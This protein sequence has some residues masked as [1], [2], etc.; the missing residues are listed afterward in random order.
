MVSF[1][2]STDKARAADAPLRINQTGA[3][4]GTLTKAELVTSDG[5]TQG[6]EFSFQA[7]DGSKADYL[8]LWTVN[9]EGQEL[10]GM[11]VVHALMACLQLRKIDSAP[12]T[13]KEW[14]NDAKQER[15]RSAEL[16]PDLMGK[17]VGLVLQREEYWP[18][19]GGDKKTRMALYTVFQAGTNLM[20]KEILDRKAQPEALAK[21]LGTL[22][23]RQAGERPAGR[24]NGG[25]GGHGGHTAGHRQQSGR[26]STGFDDMD[27]DIPF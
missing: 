21:L 3:Y 16:L 6:I 26:T 7:D 10:R 14:D 17:K 19:N 15:T 22:K 13:I 24:G 27:D 5:G 4:V 9:S 20:A 2:L 18:N 1:A 8:T 23:D 25:H 12:G 11:K